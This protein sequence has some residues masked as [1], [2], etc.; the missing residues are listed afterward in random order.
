MSEKNE[1][2]VNR[3]LG[4]KDVV[5]YCIEINNVVNRKYSVPTEREFFDFAHQAMLIARD[6]DGVPK[7]DAPFFLEMFEEYD[8]QRPNYEV[9][10]KFIDHIMPHI[11]KEAQ[12]NMRVFADRMLD[13]LTR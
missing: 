10:F 13:R 12:V 5:D 2:Y 3:F 9:V 7:S 11:D 8:R 1:A 6:N 4:M